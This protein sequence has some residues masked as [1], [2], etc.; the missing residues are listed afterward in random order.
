MYSLSL[1]CGKIFHERLFIC[2]KMKK[3]YRISNL[4]YIGT[5]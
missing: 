1:F 3:I 4:E 5:L 2:V